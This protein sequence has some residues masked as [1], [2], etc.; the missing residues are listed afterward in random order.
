M[1]HMGTGPMIDG[2]SAA[3]LQT[4]DRNGRDTTILA[5]SSGGTVVGGLSMACNP[6]ATSRTLQTHRCHRKAAGSQ[7]RWLFMPHR[8]S[9]TKVLCLRLIPM[10]LI[11]PLDILRLGFPHHCPALLLLA[12]QALHQISQK[13]ESSCWNWALI[14][15]KDWFP[16]CRGGTARLERDDGTSGISSWA[17]R[18]L[19]EKCALQDLPSAAPCSG[20]KKTQVWRSTAA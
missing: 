15:V 9:C 13:I 20:K 2:I 10:L 3:F 16:L 5:T 12:F 1:S 8:I 11:V 19:Q 4:A 7:M 17:L 18:P 6:N 14:L